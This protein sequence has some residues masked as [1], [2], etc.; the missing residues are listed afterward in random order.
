MRLFDIDFDLSIIYHLHCS[1]Y[2]VIYTG[3]YYTKKLIEFV[4]QI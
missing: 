3:S 2:A 1:V 4:L